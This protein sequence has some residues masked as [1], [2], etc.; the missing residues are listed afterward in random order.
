MA[1]I[2]DSNFCWHFAEI[3]G[4]NTYGAKDANFE[5][6]KGNKYESLVRESI[7]NSLD[8]ADNK[9]YPVKVTFRFRN[10]PSTNFNNFFQTLR[11]HVEACL[12]TEYDDS[13]DRKIRFEPIKNYIDKYSSSS[14]PY[15]EVSD[16]NTIGMD[17]K[18]SGSIETGR[19]AAFMKGVGVGN[20]TQGEVA[21]GAFGFG[22]SAFFMLSSISTLLVSSMTETGE[23]FFEGT[24]RL[25]THFIDGQKYEPSGFFCMQGDS[26]EKPIT[27]DIPKRFNRESPGT[28][29]CV[30][31]LDYESIPQDKAINEI[32][33]AVLFN[34]W[35]A[36]F[37]KRLEVVVK[38]EN[39][40]IGI[41]ASN[42][43]SYM[44]EQF[45][46]MTDAARGHNNPRPYYEAVRL[47][48]TDKKHIK[49][50]EELQYLGKVRFYMNMCKDAP[51]DRYIYMRKELMYIHYET[52]S[53]YGFYGVFVCDGDEGNKALRPS[54]NPSHTIWDKK[55][56]NNDE[57]K[58][59]AEKAIDAMKNFVDEIQKKYF[60]TNKSSRLELIDS[61]HYLYIPTADE[62][63]D[64]ED[65]AHT[66]ASTGKIKDD[67]TSP[68]NTISKET[69]KITSSDGSVYTLVETQTSPNKNGDRYSGN[70]GGKGGNGGNT[71]PGK[72][73]N[74]ST[75]DKNGKKGLYGKKLRTTFNSWALPDAVSNRMYHYICLHLYN[76]P[77]N[78][79][80]LVLYSVGEQLSEE[81]KIEK[82]W[83]DGNEVRVIENCVTNLVADAN[84]MVKIKV[85]FS[86]NYEHSLT[87]TAYEK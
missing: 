38:T 71:P 25:S 61:N 4:G 23:K 8:A 53:R 51:V 30:M 50:D 39:S 84:S 6:F 68:T 41:N 9:G 10:I 67:G 80:R 43:Q 62:D 45:P 1:N 73:Q 69:T 14:M 17:Y 15:L 26:Y 79:G 42:L 29:V 5:H 47:A 19:F 86:D 18:M 44:E 63:D 81:I 36:V 32:I 75:E 76:E 31:G 56:C 78:K 60:A 83:V 87:V 35:L 13:K 82:A 24:S 57:Q 21:G 52:L 55:L 16:E 77:L 12:G 20:K 72:G 58:N 49:I 66:G 64:S 28:T 74:K 65:T 37:D 59:A 85:A 33:R 70:G 46:D 48:G 2:L 22:K 34:F 27:S 40:E 3:T 11:Q 54:E 7:Q